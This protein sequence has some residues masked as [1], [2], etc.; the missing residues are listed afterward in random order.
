MAKPQ[1]ECPWH[2][3][4]QWSGFPGFFHIKDSFDRQ[5]RCVSFCLGLTGL[6]LVACL[7]CHV[8][9]LL[10]ETFH[11]A[12]YSRS[13]CCSF[14]YHNSCLLKLAIWIIHQSNPMFLRQR[15]T[16]SPSQI[17]FQLH[18][19]KLR[20]NGTHSLA[21]T[22]QWHVHIY[23]TAQSSSVYCETPRRSKKFDQNGKRSSWSDYKGW[24]GGAC[25]KGV[26]SLTRQQ[27]V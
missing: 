27:A 14:L 1:T 24:R 9:Y 22:F 21:C 2:K 4:F 3:Y 10:H 12:Q 16:H 19:E 26:V 15:I 18:K 7:F 5:R 6:L 13:Q 25:G 11:T 8:C 20:V 17:F 23:W